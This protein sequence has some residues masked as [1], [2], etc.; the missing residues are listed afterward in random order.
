MYTK[1]IHLCFS[2]RALYWLDIKSSVHVVMGRNVLLQ[3]WPWKMRIMNLVAINVIQ[4]LYTK[5]FFNN[6]GNWRK[7]RKDISN[8]NVNINSWF[9]KSY[10]LQIHLV[11]LILQF[12]LQFLSFWTLKLSLELLL[13]YELTRKQLKF[14]IIYFQSILR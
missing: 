9:R 6:N 10:T 2:Y 12:C 5:N 14:L 8:K 7:N 4:S 13:H 1:N 11:S 3:A